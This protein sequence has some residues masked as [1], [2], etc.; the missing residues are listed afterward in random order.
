MIWKSS[1]QNVWKIFLGNTLISLSN[2]RTFVWSEIDRRTRCSYCDFSL[3]MKDEEVKSK[4][5]D[6]FKENQAVGNTPRKIIIMQFILGEFS[7]RLFYVLLWILSVFQWGS[8]RAASNHCR[9]Y[10][11]IFL[12]HPPFS[13]GHCLM[14][15]PKQSCRRWCGQ[16]P[17]EESP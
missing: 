4:E 7:N 17:V 16:K 5:N 3:D 8:Q 6:H 15:R 11:K 1:E 13:I 12:P 10:W 2:K 14:R 9:R